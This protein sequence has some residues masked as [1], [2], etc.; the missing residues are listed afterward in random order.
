MYFKKESSKS[1]VENEREERSVEIVHA[2]T[3]DS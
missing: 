3:D 2:S 1:C